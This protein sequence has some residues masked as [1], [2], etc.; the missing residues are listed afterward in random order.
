MLS[1]VFILQPSDDLLLNLTR[2]PKICRTIRFAV[3]TLSNETGYSVVF[4]VSLHCYEKR[5]WKMVDGYRKVYH[6]RSHTDIHFRG[7]LP[8]MD[9]LCRW[10]PDNSLHLGLGTLPVE[11]Q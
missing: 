6:D 4:L 7:V 8:K 9:S 2:N 10:L 1:F 5:T 3:I 11:R